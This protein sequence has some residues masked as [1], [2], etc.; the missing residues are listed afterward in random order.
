MN[1]RSESVSPQRSGLERLLV[2]SG[3]Y[4]NLRA[5]AAVR[6]AAAAV[7]AALAALMLVLGV[8]WLALLLLVVADVAFWFGFWVWS[9][10][11]RE[12]DA[13]TRS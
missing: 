10:A 13:S 3:E 1:G 7:L 12:A 5:Y 2:R 6:F 8:L 4:R 9:L 11:R